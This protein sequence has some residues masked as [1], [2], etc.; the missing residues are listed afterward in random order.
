MTVQQGAGYVSNDNLSQVSAWILTIPNG[1][2][3]SNSINMNTTTLVGL[4]IAPIFT[5][6][7]ISFEVSFDDVTFFPVF[8]VANTAVEITGVVDNQFY[9]LSPQDFAFIPFLRLVSNATELQDSN[10]TI[11]TRKV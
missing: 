5:G 8:T 7:T 9:G 10:L 3:V 4:L 6:T 1:E 11:V 2:T